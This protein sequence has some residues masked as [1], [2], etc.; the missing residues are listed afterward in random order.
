MLLPFKTHKAEE[1][2]G[3]YVRNHSPQKSKGFTLTTF[4]ADSWPDGKGQYFTC[5]A[6][7]TKIS[8]RN[9][10]NEEC[11]GVND[12][13]VAKKATVQFFPFC[14]GVVWLYLV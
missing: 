11:D 6:G 2:L 10:W 5:A 3:V 8:K 13:T 7:Y 12:S 14:V 9:K 4:Y 1:E